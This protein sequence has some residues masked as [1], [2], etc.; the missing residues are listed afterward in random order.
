[1]A[2]IKDGYGLVSY[3][4]NTGN[5]TY[6][7]KVPEEI[8]QSI[9]D[10]G[11]SLLLISKKSSTDISPHKGDSSINRPDRYFIIIGLPNKVQ[12][13]ITN[14]KD[15]QNQYRN[16]FSQT[17]LKNFHNQLGYPHQRPCMLPNTIPKAP[18]RRNFSPIID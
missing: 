11:V 12:L 14:I 1:M 15:L 3:D 4:T 18:T 5:I 17:N 9:I 10:R 2:S 13:A 6:A 7:F 16:S 8:P